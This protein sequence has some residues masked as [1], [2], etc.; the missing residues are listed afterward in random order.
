MIKFVNCLC[1]TALVCTGT[2]AATQDKSSASQQSQEVQQETKASTAQ[3]TTKMKTDT[4]SGKIESFDPGKS[5]KIT[6]PGKIVSSRS[7]S[8]NNKDWTYN[9]P[10]NLK[11]GDW[12]RINEKTDNSG[13]K[14]VTIQHSS[15]Q[16]TASRSKPSSYR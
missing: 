5:I 12:I 13:H 15:K 16:G 2:F 10:N 9:V 4:V 8:L 6:V 7:W 11:P 14:T 3:G 1:T